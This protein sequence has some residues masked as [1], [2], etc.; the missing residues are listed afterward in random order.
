[1]PKKYIKYSLEIADKI[2]ALLGEG[3]TFSYTCQRLGITQTSLNNWRKKYPEFDKRIESAIELF[4][5]KCPENLKKIARDRIMEVAKNGLKITR[6]RTTETTRIHHIPIYDEQGKIIDYKEK[7]RQT[8]TTNETDETN[9][10][11]P[12]WVVDRILPPPPPN[13]ESAIKI[14]ESYGL[15]AVVADPQIFRQWLIAQENDTSGN[16]GRSAK[17]LQQ[18]EANEIRAKILGLNPETLD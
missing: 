4:R 14:L 2:V 6:T 7:W 11:V 15:K 12:Q 13:I 1:M 9:M 8:E 3:Q 10:G 17:G 18:D 16:N 5:E